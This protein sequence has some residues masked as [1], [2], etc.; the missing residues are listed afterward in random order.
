MGFGEP[1][2]DIMG[3]VFGSYLLGQCI[4]Y[5]QALYLDYNSCVGFIP[6]LKCDFE[7]CRVTHKSK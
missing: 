5:R 6:T 1:S 3:H 4:N 7:L 2:R